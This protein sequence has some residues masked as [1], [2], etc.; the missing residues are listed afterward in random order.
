MLHPSH[1]KL[2]HPQKKEMILS[3]FRPLQRGISVCMNCNNTK[4]I[5]AVHKLLMSLMNIFP[6]ESANSQV[7]SKYEELEALYA[8]VSKLI[9]EGLNN[10]EKYDVLLFEYWR[11]Y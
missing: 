3:S 1:V 2:Y 6:T 8:H 7:A 10:Y 5:R 9:Y 4:V 11:C